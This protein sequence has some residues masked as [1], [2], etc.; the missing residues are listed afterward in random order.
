MVL[1]QINTF[2]FIV[3]QSGCLWGQ[4]PSPSIH[5]HQVYLLIGCPLE[6]WIDFSCWKNTWLANVLSSNNLCRQTLGKSDCHAQVGAGMCNSNTVRDAS[7]VA[8]EI[9]GTSLLHWWFCQHTLQQFQTQQHSMY[10]RS[11]VDV[12]HP[13]LNWPWEAPSIA[14]CHHLEWH[15]S[16]CAELQTQQL[17]H[18]HHHYCMASKLVALTWGDISSFRVLSK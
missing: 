12:R 15:K 14:Q 7:V 13:C 16:V 3:P 6:Q 11:S 18:P 17:H 1:Y 10:G 8:F 5:A 4:P 9:N 2:T